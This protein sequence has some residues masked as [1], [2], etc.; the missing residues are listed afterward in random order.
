MPRHR[1][2]MVKN[3]FPVVAKKSHPVR[4]A[5]IFDWSKIWLLVK[6]PVYRRCWPVSLRLEFLQRVLPLLV[7]AERWL[8]FF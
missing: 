4:V 3:E 7:V 2:G 5:L 8:L 1:V 6:N